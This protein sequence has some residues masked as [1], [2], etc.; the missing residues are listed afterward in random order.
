MQSHKLS[1]LFAVI[2]YVASALLTSCSGG[3]SGSNNSSN[4]PD[5]ENV[6]NEVGIGDVG[7]L[8][9]TTAWGDFNSDGKQDLIVANTDIDSSSRNVFLFKNDGNGTFSDVTSESGIL[10][11][12][13]RSVAWADVNNDGFLDL[14]VGTIMAGKP[15]ILYKN[16][17]DGVFV[18]FSEEAGI[19]RMGGEIGHTIWA[20]Y[21]RDG[22]VDLFQANSGQ[23]FLYHNQGDEKFREV[24]EESRLE[25]FNTNSAV[26]FD[27][28]NDGFLDLFLVNDGLNSLFLNNGYGTFTDFTDQAGVGGDQDWNSVAACVGD[29]NGDR[30][31]DL[32]VVNISSNRPVRNALYRNNGGRTFTDV[33]EETG[34]EDVGDGRTCAWVDFDNDGRLDLFTTNHV[35]PSKLFRNLGNGMFADVATQVGLG[36]PDFPDCPIDIFA[37]SWGDY[38]NDGFVDVFFNGHIGKGLMENSGTENNFLIIELIGNGETTNTSAIGVRVEVV[39]S[40]GLQIREVSG[41]RGCCEQDMLP[42]HFGVGQEKEVDI[43]VNWADEDENVCTF[44]AVDVEGGPLFLISEDEC[45]R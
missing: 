12:P 1:L 17:G 3:S 42:L 31:F 11:L 20:D 41:G 39:T 8:G 23:S 27:F 13:L 34:T 18:D 37:A 6:S 22:L 5:F 15:P 19:T 30:F 43:K 45:V 44:N 28:N 29:F 26:W 7:A 4:F 21:D 9:Q 36:C 10:D 32:Y 35:N 24:S 16:I 38:N 14:V 25:E 40:E 2:S 33:T